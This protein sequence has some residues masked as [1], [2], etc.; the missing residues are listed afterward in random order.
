MRIWDITRVIWCVFYTHTTIALRIAAFETLPTS[1]R[2]QAFEPGIPRIFSLG[3]RTV[4]VRDLPRGM[5]K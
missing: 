2:R 1:V 4:V 5:M 3:F